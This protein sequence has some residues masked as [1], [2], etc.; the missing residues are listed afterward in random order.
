MRGLYL[1]LESL[2]GVLF[3]AHHHLFPVVPKTHGVDEV[4]L[5]CFSV[6]SIMTLMAQFSPVITVKRSNRRKEKQS[7]TST[8]RIVTGD[9]QSHETVS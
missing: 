2:V 7:I 5:I 3:L 9:D 1:K 8:N 6:V 4:A